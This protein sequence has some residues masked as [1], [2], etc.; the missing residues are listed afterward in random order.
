MRGIGAAT[1]AV[2]SG[3]V[4]RFVA[5]GNADGSSGHV[6]MLD[7]A[8]SMGGRRAQEDGRWNL[9]AHEV[10]AATGSYR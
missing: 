2:T 8:G 9:V 10:D 5:H 6:H 3:K 4:G 1:T 7:R